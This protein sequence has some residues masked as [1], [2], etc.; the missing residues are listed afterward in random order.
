MALS[1]EDQI[2]RLFA[3]RQSG[4]KYGPVYCDH[5]HECPRPCPCDA[6]CYCRVEGNCPPAALVT[7][8]LP[9]GVA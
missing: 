4:A 2:A 8:G 6:D 1:R 5:A 9:A 3:L 7:T